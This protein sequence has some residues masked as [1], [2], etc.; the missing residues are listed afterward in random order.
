MPAL[1][2]MSWVSKTSRWIFIW[3]TLLLW[4]TVLLLTLFTNPLEHPQ[5]IFSFDYQARQE[6]LRKTYLY[7]NVLLA[8]IFQNKIQIPVTKFESNLT[9]LLDPNNYFFGFHPR[10][11]GNNLN[12]VKFPFISL[13]V[14]AYALFHFRSLKRYKQLAIFLIFSLLSLSLLITFDR[15][16]FILYFPLALIFLSGMRLLEKRH[17]LFSA[18]YFLFS[19][20]FSLIEVLRQIA[21][22][23]PK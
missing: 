20:P 18:T 17:P 1:S 12:M 4:P 21:I 15:F 3:L 13:P 9:A 5:T 16:D 6:I 11:L 7:P 19:L 14:F 10:E 23:F 2:F 22:Y 8:R